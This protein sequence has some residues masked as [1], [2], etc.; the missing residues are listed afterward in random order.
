MNLLT[1][2]CKRIKENGGIL[3]LQLISEI[4]GNAIQKASKLEKIAIYEELKTEH[5]DWNNSKICAAMQSSA[6]T[7]SRLRRDL[8]IKSP[9]HYNI[10]SKRKRNTT[11][12]HCDKCNKEMLETSRE[13]HIKS[14]THL[15]ENIEQ[16]SHQPE[17]INEEVISPI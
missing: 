3:A 7:M 1:E 16:Q 17:L 15:Q 2:T 10:P 9:W 11:K 4:D 6:S 13:A 12:W 14:K 5:P 8:G